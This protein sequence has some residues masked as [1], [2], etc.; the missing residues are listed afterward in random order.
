MKFYS[1]SPLPEMPDFL[2]NFL[3][4]HFR[5]FYFFCCVTID[6]IQFTLQGTGGHEG[7]KGR[8]VGLNW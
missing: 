2:S 6:L 5:K 7:D 8:K 1:M 4:T 3:V